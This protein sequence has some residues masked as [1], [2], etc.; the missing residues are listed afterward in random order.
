MWLS[1]WN[2]FSSIPWKSAAAAE[3]QLACYCLQRIGPSSKAG[4][5]LIFCRN[6]RQSIMDNWQL[7]GQIL[8]WLHYKV[9]GPGHCVDWRYRVSSSK[10]RW[11]CPSRS[12]VLGALDKWDRLCRGLW[13]VR[14]SPAHSWR[15]CLS[16]RP[17]AA[18]NCSLKSNSSQFSNLQQHVQWTS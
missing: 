5:A 11:F 9:T 14:V 15:D 4:S 3:Y 18:A 1:N 6:S 10:Q 12:H 13:A 8:T 7:A 17:L 2:N 16:L